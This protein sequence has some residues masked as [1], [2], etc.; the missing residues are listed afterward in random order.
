MQKILVLDDN[1]D[2]LEAVTM[3]LRRR[4]LEVI[5]IEDPEQLYKKIDQHQPD[6][7]LMDIALGLY[8]GRT[9][10]RKLKNDPAHAHL[11]VILFSAQT[12]TY[13]SVEESGADGVLNKPFHVQALF[14]TIDQLLK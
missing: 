10:C 11:P 9:L 3:V 1:H 13:E 6:L 2:I 8:D 12:F 5:A 4:K 7:V 14:S